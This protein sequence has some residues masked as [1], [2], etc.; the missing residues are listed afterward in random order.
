MSARVAYS[1]AVLLA[2]QLDHA[3]ATARAASR[4][5]SAPT[6]RDVPCGHVMRYSTGGTRA[7]CPVCGALEDLRELE[8]LRTRK[9]ER[10]PAL[11]D[12]NKAG[13]VRHG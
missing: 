4:S 1:R 2:D 10:P 6:G 12:W 8:E 13:T 7:G 5:S 3:L 9:G 11:F